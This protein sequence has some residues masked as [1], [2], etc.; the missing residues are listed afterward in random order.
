MGRME[1]HE[2]PQTPFEVY[3]YACRVT[4]AAGTSHCVHCGGRL[5]GRAKR[6]EA[7]VITDLP[8]GEVGQPGIV[9]RLGGM[10]LWVLI[11]LGAA[12]SRMCGE[13]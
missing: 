10:S 13:G 12:L 7:A 5:G 4:F 2:G 9:R 11:A 6:G 8:D 3:C 1:R